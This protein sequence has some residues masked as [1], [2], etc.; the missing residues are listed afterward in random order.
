M[1]NTNNN[2]QTQTSNALHNAIME[3]DG[4]DRP[5]MLAPGNNVQWKSKIK[6]YINT[7]P[8]NKLIHYC[9]YNPPYKFKW[10][11]KTIL[12]AEGSSKTTTKGYM[13]NYKNVSQDIRNQLD[14]EA[15]VKAIERLKQGESI[16][17]KDLETN[18][19]W[20]FR[21]F[22]SSDGESLKSYYSRIAKNEVNEIRAERLARTANPLALVAQQQPVYHPQNHPTHYTQNSSTRPQQAATRNK[23]KAIVNSP[24]PIY[25]QE[26]AMKIYKPTNKNLKTSSNTSRVHQDNTPRIN[27]ET[28]YDNQMAVNVAGARENVK[29]ADWRDDTDDEPEDQELEAHYLYM[30]HNQEVT[31]DAADNSG[32]IFDAKPLQKVQ[33]DNDNYNI[34]ANDS[35]HAEQPESI[36]DTYLK[37]HGDTNITT[38]PLDMSNNEGE[39]DEDEDENE[40]LA[41]ERDLLA[42]LIEKLQCEID[43][44]KDHTPPLNIQT[45]PETTSQAPAQAPTVTTTENI[46]QAD[47][48]K[49]NAQVEED[50]FINIFSTPL[51]TDGEICMFA[52]TVSRIKP[53]NIKEAMADSAWIEAMQEE[54]LQF[55]RLD[56]WEL[57]DRP[58]CKNV[59]KMK[60]LWKN[61]RDEENTVIRNKARFVA[62]GY[63]QKEGID[64]EES[65]APVAR[66]EA[67]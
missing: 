36:N 65:F 52:L 11:E 53:K 39:G 30:A 6:R 38:D 42:S 66:L 4:K 48:H 2:L 7:I 18:L 15:E 40:D 41:R 44:S 61:K 9:L 10:A 63:G 24:Q 64:F 27:R 1:S 51:E 28:W 31:P 50:E 13:E 62:K 5:P 35:E 17:V 34:F 21:K 26:P 19:Y 54:L 12:V 55:N 22:T 16:N 67:V 3:A 14:A 25:D 43:E 20:V 58:L 60:W 23:G 46:N 8:N 47:T 32:P 59:I 49:E 56:V 45:T 37:E 29:Q 33:N 57:V